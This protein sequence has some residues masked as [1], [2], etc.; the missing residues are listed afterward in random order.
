MQQTVV[1]PPATADAAPDAIVSYSA[2]PG[3]RKWTCTSIKPGVTKHPAA[4][5]T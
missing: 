1:N 5:I 3:S 2:S 4:S